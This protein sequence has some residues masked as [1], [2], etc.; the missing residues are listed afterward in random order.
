MTLLTSCTSKPEIVYQA[1]PTVIPTAL[2][3]PCDDVPFIGE[4]FGDVVQYAVRL[5]AEYRIC[6]SRLAGLI[7]W[8][9]KNDTMVDKS[10]TD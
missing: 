6:A 4:H 3:Q 2:L 5:K 10:K 8:S 7:E 9:K 1:K